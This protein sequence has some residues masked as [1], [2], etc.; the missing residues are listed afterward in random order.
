M[1]I[2]EMYKRLTNEDKSHLT[3]YCIYDTIY[4]VAS[5]ENIDI[6]DKLVTDIQELA[7]ALYLDDEYRNLSTS[8][9]AFF[10][11]ECYVKD[12]KFMEKVKDMDYEDILQA[13]EDGNYE[14]YSKD[15]IE[16]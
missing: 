11:T 1:N 16:R 3:I 13:I 7:Y 6:S 14:F 9:I 10:L 12:N 4:D 8:Q 2:L 5:N 15:E